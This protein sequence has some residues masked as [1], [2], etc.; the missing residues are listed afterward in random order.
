MGVYISNDQLQVEIANPGEVY[1]GTRFDWTGFITQVKWK[2]HHGKVHTF[3]V[4]ESLI[5]GEGTG[6]IGLWNE[7][8]IADPIGYDEALPGDQFPKLGVGRLTRLDEADYNFFRNYPVEL[9]DMGT[10]IEN[11][12]VYSKVQAHP[13]NGYAAELSKVIKLVDN[14]LSIE[15]KLSNTGIKPIHT[16]EYVHNFLRIDE[17]PVGPAYQLTLPIQIETKDM[18]Q[19]Y[20]PS[21]LRVEGKQVSWNTTPSQAFYARIEDV[22][23]PD[24]ATW[25]LVHRPSGIGVREWSDFKVKTIALWGLQHVVSPEV[26]IQV[27]VQPGETQC[28][29]R[30][31]EFFSQ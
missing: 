2:D 13:C 24:G 19:G 25:E 23:Q 6:G 18:E 27:A 16:E 22:E 28:W 15:Y 14:T 31:Y 21:I 26:F 10:S 5:D 3:C 17:H 11:N 30:K 1:Q 9:F 12:V 8:G 20:S 7:F 29:T 4:P